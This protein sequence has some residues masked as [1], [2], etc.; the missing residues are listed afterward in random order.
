MPV[1][2]GS[3]L[4]PRPFDRGGL[5]GVSYLSVSLPTLTHPRETWFR[6][7][8]TREPL[9]PEWVSGMDVRPLPTRSGSAPSEGFEPSGPLRLHGVGH[10]VGG[11][12]SPRVRVLPRFDPVLPLYSDGNAASRI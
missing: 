7:P 9:P 2:E 4:V 6:L 1:L 12:G 11:E 8:V 5:V 3:T 10:P